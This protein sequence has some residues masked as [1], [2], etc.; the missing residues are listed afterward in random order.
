MLLCS[1]QPKAL[2]WVPTAA[3]HIAQKLLL[4]RRGRG[5][6]WGSKSHWKVCVED[7]GWAQGFLKQAGPQESSQVVD[8]RAEALGWV[9]LPQ[10][11]S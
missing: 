1:A 10:V 3:S 2:P 8:G 6:P 9:K 4:L 11:I 7:N 5:Q